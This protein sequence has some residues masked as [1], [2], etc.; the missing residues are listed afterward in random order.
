V[1][2]SAL[3]VLFFALPV[4]LYAHHAVAPN[5]DLSKEI[6]LSEAVLTSF[7]FV[8]PHVYL[9]VDVP[10]EQNTT[11]EW[12][13]EMAAASRLK[14]RGWTAETLIPG[15]VV[16]IKGSPGLRENNVCHVDA[17]KQ[18]DGSILS[19]FAGRPSADEVVGGLVSVEDAQSR[20]AYLPNGQRNLSGPWVTTQQSLDVPVIE[21]TIEGKQAG[22][23]LVRHF[24]SPA[25]SC[26]P[27]NI[28]YDW[29]FE[30][31]S[32]EIYQEGDEITLK[33]GYLDQQ[34]TIF[35]NVLEHPLDLSPSVTGHSI[36]QWEGD[37]LVVD[38]VGF[39]PGVLS[40][41]GESGFSMHSEQWHVTERFSVSD[42]GRTLTRTYTFD[43]PRYM[44]GSYTQQD[45]ASLT[46]E[47][48]VPYGCEDLGGENNVRP[49]LD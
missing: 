17:I 24:D 16:S 14:R 26:Q 44:L 37:E 39:L 25:L 2:Y 36:G 27:T 28:V 35:L 23:G 32:N 38:T 7:K 3:L 15:Q 45:T 46:T 13:C 9:Y 48:Y 29:I 20:P 43:D 8:N 4:P 1:K 40:Y 31:E 30:R 5:F 42:D 10:N 34:R 21:P 33:Y 41:V 12:R 11:D 49:A 6:V 19:E 22:L 18:A 47:P